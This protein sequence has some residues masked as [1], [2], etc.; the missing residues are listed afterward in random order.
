MKVVHDWLTD[1]LGENAPTPE[2]IEELLTFHAF[3]IDGVEKEGEHTIIDV[4]V[5]PNR[6]ADCLSHRGI[7]R[8][9]A[10]ITGVTLTNDPLAE[11]LP[12]WPMTPSLTI[13]IETEKS[14]RQMGAIVRGVKIG[15]S[16]EWLR[17]R[18]E[19]LGQHSINNV[20]DATNYVTLSLGQPLHAFDVHKISNNNGVTHIVIR[21][22]KEGEEITTLSK[23]TYVLP[24]GTIVIADGGNNAPLDIAGIKGGAMS[25]IDEET[26]DL[27][28][29][30]AN[31]DAVKIRKTSQAIKLTTDA[32]TRFQ[33]RLSPELAPYALRSILELVQ[34]LAGGEIEGVVD[35]YPLPVAQP[36]VEVSVSKTNALLGLSVPKEEMKDILVRIGAEVEETADGFIAQGPWERNDLTIEE[37]FIEEIGRIHGY[38]NVADVVPEKVPLAEINARHYY[39]ERAREVLIAQGFSEVI[40]SSFRKKD[41][42]RLQNALASDKE[43]LRSSLVKNITEV[44]DKNIPLVDL[45]G[46]TDI[47]V[48]EIGTVFKKGEG[49]IEEYFSLAF[50]VRKRQD[51]YNLK[52]DV[53]LK[54][55][56]ET[57]EKELGVSFDAKIEK[58]VAEINFTDL[59]S[60]LPVPH[61]YE[62]ETVSAEIQYKPFSQY[63]HTARDIALWV[64]EGTV[65]DEV[66]A[67]LKSEAGDL[68]VR[69]T[70]FDEFTKE[71]RTSYAFRLVFQS[72]E[73]TL[74]S[75]EVDTIM[76]RIYTAVKE[77]GFEVR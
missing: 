14:A 28:V 60:K 58:G 29:S 26:T 59:V 36:K 30:V 42:V 33:N 41:E 13:S 15:P 70:L 53:L 65:G 48:F 31:F 32:S 1:Y 10:S 37:D 5:L 19:A 20:V 34:D 43:Y 4:S 7:A 72:Y 6:G 51:G 12:K 47:R 76:E 66:A 3:E 71:G 50:G 38:E 17:T 63:P 75:D 27:Y 16:P 9:I 46:V 49:D 77:K 23:E 44:L 22:T 56:L 18:L 55:I 67:I 11:A 57:F 62:K 35:E 39:S 40:T 8:E 73:K 54:E 45:L 64:T 68:C 25:A 61:A 2:K 24:A 69:L 74:A 52:D 21:E